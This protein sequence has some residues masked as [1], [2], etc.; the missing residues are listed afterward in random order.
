[1]KKKWRSCKISRI[2][3]GTLVTLGTFG[4][5]IGVL[6]IIPILYQEVRFNKHFE[7][8][9]QGELLTYFIGIL[10]TI[11]SAFIGALALYQTHELNKK[12]EEEKIINTKRPFFVIYKVFADQEEV[13]FNNNGW[14]FECEKSPKIEIHLKNVGDGLA[15]N[16]YWKKGFGKPRHD[17]KIDEIILEG[18]TLIVHPPSKSVDFE[19][20]YKNILDCKYKQIIKITRELKQEIL[21]QESIEDE[22]DGHIETYV[23][24]TDAKDIYEFNIRNIT[25][26]EIIKE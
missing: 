16:V 6:Y 12:I 9:T 24:T 5:C 25:S 23:V 19:I 13:N 22:V 1:M 4:M 17:N 3:L 7:Y 15:T 14:I 26:Q 10:G 20:Q 21:M 8:I 18:G 11:G 2:I